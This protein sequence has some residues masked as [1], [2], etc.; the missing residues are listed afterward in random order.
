MGISFAYSC[1][2]FVAGIFMFLAPCTLPLVP[3]LIASLSPQSEKKV[4]QYTT[5]RLFHIVLFSIGFT[6]V[7]VLLGVLTGVFGSRLSFY[8]QLIS[9]IGGIIVILFGLSLLGV[10]RLHI[11]QG[12]VSQIFHLRE[13][14]PYG[15]VTIGALFALG[16]SPC[17]GPLLTSILVLASQSNTALEGG[18]LL[19]AFSLG[20]MI[21]FM[22]V[23]TLYVYTLGM[24]RLY[25]RYQKLIS[26]VSGLFLVILGVLLVFG[27]TFLLTEWGATF[28][29]YFGYAPVCSFM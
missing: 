20:V 3:A 14:G 5:A 29:S 13:P 2:A 18:I 10:F 16:W 27:Q 24:L 23:G 6:T 15:A 8:R 25:E 21:P 22:L 7:F 11:V 17:A 12:N 28:L 9:E 4:T 26:I 19:T 1:T